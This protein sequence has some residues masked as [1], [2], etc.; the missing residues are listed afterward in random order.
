VI[1]SY[2]FLI[3]WVI[4]FILLLLEFVLKIMEDGGNTWVQ[5]DGLQSENATWFK[6]YAK[7]Y[8][9][10]HSLF[11]WEPYLYWKPDSFQGTYIN[12]N[13]DGLRSTYNP[14]NTGEQ[15]SP[16]RI[17][18]FG[19]STMWGAGARDH[20]TIASV[21]SRLLGESGV[22][23]RISNFAQLGYVNS[24]EVM[25]LLCELKNDNLPVVAIFYD[26]FNDVFS[27]F[28]N[29]VAGI[30]LKETNR[31]IEFNITKSGGRLFKSF[32]RNLRIYNLFCEKAQWKQCTSAGAG[33]D[34][35]QL[36]D[37]VV[38]IVRSNIKLVETLGTAHGFSS[39]FYWQPT[40]FHKKELTEYEQNQARIIEPARHFFQATYRKIESCDV[41][42]KKKNFHY[43]ADL[44]SDSSKPYYID[45]GHITEGGD[46][47]VAKRMATD[48]LK[49]IYQL[50]EKRGLNK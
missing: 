4:L 25:S 40:I 6:E 35:N 37:D 10:V 31:R 38:R 2:I 20:K 11:R 43:V 1:M 46:L 42:S 18:M 50:K 49:V 9:K 5:A 23:A 17:F 15:Q 47:R 8:K 7:E 24:Q 29:G 48:V 32:V 33:T 14:K 13:K 28:T 12:I 16:I 34:E 41:L 26:G 22:N 36:S 39:L 21:L 19:G 45:F 3:P 27:A 30:P 44:F